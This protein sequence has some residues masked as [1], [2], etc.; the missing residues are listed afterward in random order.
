MSK[1]S[2][3]GLAF[4][5]ITLFAI[6]ITSCQKVNDL[7][8]FDIP[9]EYAMLIPQNQAVGIPVSFD[10]EDIETNIRNRMEEYNTSLDMVDDVFLTE[11]SM[12]MMDP[13]NADFNF[14]DSVSVRLSSPG[15]GMWKVAWKEPVPDGV[16]G[17]LNM[18]VWAGT[19]LKDHVLNDIIRIRL[20]LLTDEAIDTDRELKVRM[21]FH[22]NARVL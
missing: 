2:G 7:V 3:S 18:D 6:T 17:K 13:V 10:S 5:A 1:S 8:E 20:D 15:H 9:F 4:V 19:D 21:V 11:F 16:S 22:V 12:E 14:L